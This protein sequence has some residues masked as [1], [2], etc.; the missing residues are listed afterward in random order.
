MSLQHTLGLGAFAVA[1]E[2]VV[3]HD[4]AEQVGEG[5]TAQVV[6]PPDHF[7]LE[8][9]EPGQGQPADRSRMHPGDRR[10]RK[11]RQREVV[12]HRLKRPRARRAQLGGNGKLGARRRAILL[13]SEIIAAERVVEGHL[14]IFRKCSAGGTE[15]TARITGFA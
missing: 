9:L 15:I 2:D 6:L 14:N 7:G 11:A 4:R 1:G 12:D 3:V 13:R 10:G 5:A 8:R